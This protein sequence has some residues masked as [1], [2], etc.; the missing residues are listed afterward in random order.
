MWRFD[1]AWPEKSLALEFEGGVFANGRHIRGA[2]FRDDCEK[3]N[4][5]TALGWKVLRVTDRHVRTGEALSW[6][7]R[8]L[9]YVD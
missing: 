2:G 6:V 5:A 9:G 4:E 7:K 1:F 8:C 3:Y